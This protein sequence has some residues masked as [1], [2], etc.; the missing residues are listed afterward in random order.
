MT[1]GA[2]VADEIIAENAAGEALEEEIVGEVLLET[3]AGTA[4][5]VPVAQLAMTQKSS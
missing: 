4:P 3:G 2:A 1:I 5:G